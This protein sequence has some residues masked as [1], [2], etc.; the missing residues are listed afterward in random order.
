[1]KTKIEIL[2]LIKN[3]DGEVSKFETREKL[4]DCCGN[5]YFVDFQSIDWAKII[6]NEREIYGNRSIR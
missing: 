5:I 2:Q 1:M 3:M 4:V 6:E